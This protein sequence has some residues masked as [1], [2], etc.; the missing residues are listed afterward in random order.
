MTKNDAG[1]TPVTDKP[2]GVDRGDEAWPRDHWHPIYDS[3]VEWLD[4]EAPAP[5]PKAV[6]AA[7]NAK[8]KPGRRG[9]GS[10]R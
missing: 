7:R 3:V 8:R 10:P 6:A 1:T 4:N 9:N 2:T 5:L